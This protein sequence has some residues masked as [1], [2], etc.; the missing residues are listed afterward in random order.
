[1]LKPP[2]EQ[3]QQNKRS[4]GT[5]NGKKR[6]KKTEASELDYQ[7]NIHHFFRVKQTYAF[8]DMFSWFSAIRGKN[9]IPNC[10]FFVMI[11]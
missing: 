1:M 5:N 8:D 2:P 6:W 10:F 3:K 11:C 4:D 7:K 9:R